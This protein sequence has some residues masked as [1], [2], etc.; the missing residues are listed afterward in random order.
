MSAIRLRC[1]RPVVAKKPLRRIGDGVFRTI[2]EMAYEMASCEWRDSVKEI[3]LPLFR[4]VKA[5][6]D[7]PK[8][9]NGRLPPMRREEGWVRRLALMYSDKLDSNV[10]ASH[11]YLCITP[12][13]CRNYLMVTIHRVWEDFNRKDALDYFVTIK[14]YRRVWLQDGAYD[15][16]IYSTY[17]PLDEVEVAL[18]SLPNKNLTLIT[19]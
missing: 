4:S 3:L 8:H 12:E 15:K 5:Y 6:A 1:K 2:V 9:F 18:D 10:V 11:E 14:I 13:G 17:T 7:K 19:A 16:Y